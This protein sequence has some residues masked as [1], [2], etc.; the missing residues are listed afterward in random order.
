MAMLTLLHLLS[1]TVG[2]GL[3]KNMPV[4]K[5]VPSPT[6]YD[7]FLQN[8]KTNFSA[9]SSFPLTELSGEPLQEYCHVA[10]P[11]KNEVNNSQW[12]AQPQHR[13]QLLCY[14]L[15]MTVWSV[16]LH[17]ETKVRR[18]IKSVLIPDMDASA[19]VLV[20]GRVVNPDSMNGFTNLPLH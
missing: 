14:S 12:W 11:S 13:P 6:L 9:C 8:T 15:F 20:G 4:P 10:P 17:S 3:S 16:C 5:D 7:N 2:L 1:C 19:I 18:P